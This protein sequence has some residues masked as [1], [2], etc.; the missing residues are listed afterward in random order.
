MKFVGSGGSV[1]CGKTKVLKMSE[2]LASVDGC[3]KLEIKS[4]SFDLPTNIYSAANQLN[5]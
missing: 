3:A 1:S 2:A 5:H 4:Q